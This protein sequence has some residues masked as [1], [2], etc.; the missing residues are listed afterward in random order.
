[1]LEYNIGKWYLCLKNVIY[2]RNSINLFSRW[3]FCGDSYGKFG[4]AS[5][6]NRICDM[7]C[8]GD[9]AQICGGSNANSI[10]KVPTK[11]KFFH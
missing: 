6:I 5:S 2:F 11:S 7:S 3:C 1:M 9:S 8:S 4:L 10:Y